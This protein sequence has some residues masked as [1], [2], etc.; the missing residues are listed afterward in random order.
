MAGIGERL[1]G[2]WRGTEAPD[3]PKAAF[4]R[5]DAARINQAFSRLDRGERRAILRAVNRG[6][7][8][9]RRKDA[10]IAVGVARRQ[11]RFWK[12]AWLIGPFIAGVQAL[13]TPIGVRDGIILAVWGT[14]VLGIMAT[15]WFKRARRAELRNLELIVRRRGG[16]GTK[17]TA[18]GASTRAISTSSA[19]GGGRRRSRLPGG[20]SGTDR[21]GRKADAEDSTGT[22]AEGL[23]PRPEGSRPPRPRG[24]KRR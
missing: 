7:A 13:V 24:R 14:S 16:T 11:Q 22:D 18:G 15:W 3:A 10:E 23:A 5:Q 19:K 9:E 12:R 20:P 2:V 21:A 6:V 1:R 8:V 4:S 17:S